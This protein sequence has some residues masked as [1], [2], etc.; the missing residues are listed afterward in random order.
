MQ[1]EILV[2][3]CN[4]CIPA[5]DGLESRLAQDGAHLEVRKLPC[6]GKASVQYI[7]HAL[8]GGK[9]G[10]C[11]FACPTGECALFQGNYRAQVRVE[12]AKRLLAEI[13]LDPAV[14]RLV[15]FSKNG[16]M[17]EL[18]REISDFIDGMP[19]GGKK[20]ESILQGTE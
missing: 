13:G 20:R 18:R 8:E 4:N 9:D 5:W 16:T 15:H 10:I 1:K 14:I 2:F 19:R 11:I 12:N 6:S 7:F 17:E 3:L